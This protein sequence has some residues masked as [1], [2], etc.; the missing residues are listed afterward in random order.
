[1]PLFGPINEPDWAKIPL[2]GEPLDYIKWLTHKL[3]SLWKGVRTNNDES[4]KEMKVAYDK[5]HRVE[6][7]EFQPGD[8]VLLQNTRTRTGHVITHRK[9]QT[10]PFYVLEKVKNSNIG[11][12]YQ[13][14]TL[15]GRRLNRLINAD[16]LK[17]LPKNNKFDLLCP[18]KQIVEREKELNDMS[19]TSTSNVS[20][21]NELP[22]KDEKDEWYPASKILRSRGKGHNAKFLVLFTDGSTHWCHFKDVSD[23]LK[24]EYALRKRSKRP[25]R[26]K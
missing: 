5:Q 21:A 6:E 26:T 17:L 10:K 24:R 16:R 14:S 9:F 2:T 8:L 13:L 12:A 25:S 23:N 7:R 11:T 1:M 3:S 18:P 19:T 4:K 22:S 20:P 15:E